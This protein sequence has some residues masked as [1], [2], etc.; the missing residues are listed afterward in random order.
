MLHFNNYD[1]VIFDCDGVLI[2]SNNLKIDA[3][4]VALKSLNVTEAKLVVCKKFF[5]ENF[6]KSRFYHVEHFVNNILYLKKSEVH[7]FKEKLLLAYSKQCKELYLTA[8]LTPFIESLL[9]KNSAIKYVASGSEQGEL[10]EVFKQ[11][12][13]DSYFIDILGSPEKKHTHVTDILNKHKKLT[14]VM[15]GD[16]ISDLEAAKIN[17]IDFIFYSPFSNVEEK[18]RELCTQ[19]QYRIVDSF[20]EIIE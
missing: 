20:E 9:K 2:D 16:A 10:R 4:G 8:N 5:S 7:S 3:M 15:I 1:L 6:G 18:M 12:N 14:A 13:L 17:N 19:N 11:R